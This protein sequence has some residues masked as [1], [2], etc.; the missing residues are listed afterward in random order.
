MKDRFLYNKNLFYIFLFLLIFVPQNIFAVGFSP[1][2]MNIPKVLNSVVLK[3]TVNVSRNNPAKDDR[4]EISVVGDGA[5]YIKIESKDFLLP[6]GVQD[7]KFNFSI[8]PKG[9]QNGTY[10]ATIFFEPETGKTVSKDGKL[11]GASIVYGGQ[12]LVRF[13]VTDEQV[14]AGSVTS[15]KI[16][17]IEFSENERLPISFNFKNLSNVKTAP[18]KLNLVIKNSNSDIVLEKKGEAVQ[19]NDLLAP[20]D[21]GF[22]S[23]DTPVNLPLGDY[24]ANIDFLIGDVSVGIHENV[25]FKVVPVG[26]L[27]QTIEYEKFTVITKELAKAGEVAFFEATARNT[28]K[29]AYHGLLHIEILDD[30]K[31]VEIFESDKLLLVPEQRVIFKVSKPIQSA[32]KFTVRSFIDFGPNRSDE[33]TDVVVVGS[34]KLFLIGLV[35]SILTFICGI[36]FVLFKRRRRSTTITEEKSREPQVSSP[37]GDYTEQL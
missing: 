32:G 24:I 2:A 15:V 7:V 5:P 18:N 13:T 1:G 19:T 22:L 29:S 9:V 12:I 4:F 14:I 31:V 35:V 33:K 3:K 10:N 26:T 16:S 21:S 28:G 20:D 11:S 8:E 25:P 23:L 37:K 27:S 36:A 17:N 30:E 34:S 6:K